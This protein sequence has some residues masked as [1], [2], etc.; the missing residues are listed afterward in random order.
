MVGPKFTVPVRILLNRSSEEKEHPF[1][2]LKN[3]IFLCVGQ[4]D[5]A[6]VCW[7]YSANSR[8]YIK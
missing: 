8:F 1:W 6:K 2:L 3:F 4:A 7:K 5:V